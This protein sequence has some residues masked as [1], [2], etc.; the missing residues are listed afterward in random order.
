MKGASKQKNTTQ[1]NLYVS[2]FTEVFVN[3]KKI[4]L[5]EH[6]VKMALVTV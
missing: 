6:R 2:T 4:N 3:Q 1:V 5:C